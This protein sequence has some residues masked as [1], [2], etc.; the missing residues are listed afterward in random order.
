MIIGFYILGTKSMKR[1][2]KSFIGLMEECNTGDWVKYSDAEHSIEKLNYII[3]RQE[4][5]FRDNN[6]LDLLIQKRQKIVFG[7]LFFSIYANIIFLL[8]MVSS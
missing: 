8:E 7:I 2:N 4:Q 5:R 6:I 1:F 3:S